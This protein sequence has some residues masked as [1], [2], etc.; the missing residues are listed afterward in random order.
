LEDGIGEFKR[1]AIAVVDGDADE[2]AP[3]IAFGQAAMH[4]VEPD[5]IESR[6]L[7]LPDQ[8]LEEAGRHLEEAIG[9][10]PVRAWRPHVVQREDHPD[11]AH[12]RAHQGVGAAE[13]ERLEARADQGILQST[14]WHTL[15]LRWHYL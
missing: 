10:E 1:V 9:L 13:I 3:E 5:N 12:E 11:T 2:A 14:Q 4:L 7:E 15:V 8:A 6:V